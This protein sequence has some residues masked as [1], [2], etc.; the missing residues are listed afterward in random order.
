MPFVPND[1]RIN[2]LG[3]KKGS[4]DRKWQSLQAMW[5]MLMKEWNY[6]TPQQRAHYSFETVKM[7]FERSIA[8]LPKDASDSL[9]NANRLLE[10][11]KALEIKDKSSRSTDVK[12]DVV[13]KLTDDRTPPATGDKPL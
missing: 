12:S 6:L 3:R 9:T 7:H 8:Q 5:D 1:P 11:I 2:R 10:E 4:K 13:S